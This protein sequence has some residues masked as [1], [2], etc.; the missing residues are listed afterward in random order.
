ME[1]SM[2]D[3]KHS[4]H[5]VRWSFVGS[6][7]WHIESRQ[8]F[9]FDGSEPIRDPFSTIFPQKRISSGALKRSKIFVSAQFKG[10]RKVPDEAAELAEKICN[11]EMHLRRRDEEGR[12]EKLRVKLERCQREIF[13]LFAQI[14]R[15]EADLSLRA[16]ELQKA[17]EQERT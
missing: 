10:N 1:G 8:L 14:Q 15:L 9:I 3:S 13:D 5:R 2:D 11:L 7:N 16:N 4:T 12:D 17:R 6:I